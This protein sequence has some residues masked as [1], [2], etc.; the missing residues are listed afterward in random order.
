M[1]T[2]KG[3]IARRISSG[4][5]DNFDR[6]MAEDEVRSERIESFL[7]WLARKYLDAVV[8]EN[9]D[10]MDADLSDAVCEAFFSFKNP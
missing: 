1:V 4:T 9:N 5:V 3:R 6:Y 10:L 2:K 7:V 8:I